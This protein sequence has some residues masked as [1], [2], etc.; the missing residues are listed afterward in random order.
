MCAR[1]SGGSSCPSLEHC[2]CVSSASTEQKASP[3][4]SSPRCL[5]RAATSSCSLTRPSS[6]FWKLSRASASACRSSATETECWSSTA[7]C[8]TSRSECR[9]SMDSAAQTCCSCCLLRASRA[10]SASPAPP[11]P[12]PS[13]AS[14][15]RRYPAARPASSCRS[16]STSASRCSV[17][18]LSWPASAR[19]P[20]L[21][22]DICWSSR[23]SSCCI[24][25]RRRL[26]GSVFRGLQSS[27]S[28]GAGQRGVT[29][30]VLTKSSSTRGSLSSSPPPCTAI[31]ASPWRTRGS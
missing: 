5:A 8:D 18:C 17:S 20:A 1:D 30:G 6:S 13:P 26:A 9:S 3:G 2:C 14:A 19:V 23:C 12:P 25:A 7:A 4:A 31:T 11:A 27:R 15:G 10:A 24:S 16:F 29:V 21:R 22:P 28:P